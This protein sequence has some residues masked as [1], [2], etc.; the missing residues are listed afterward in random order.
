MLTCVELLMLTIGV[1]VNSCVA[2]YQVIFCCY[3]NHTLDVLLYEMEAVVLLRYW[4]LES[5]SILFH[6]FICLE[7]N[8]ICRSFYIIRGIIC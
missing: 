3:L 2:K 4:K 5:S 6:V 7:V 8:I 1:H